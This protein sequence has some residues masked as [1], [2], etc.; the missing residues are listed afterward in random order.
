MRSLTLPPAGA[1]QL[2]DFDH[3]GYITRDEMLHMVDAI[4]KMVGNMVQ[5]PADEDTPEKRVN[6]IFA[7]MDTDRDGRLTWEEF[8]EG[9]KKDPS[10]VQVLSLYDGLVPTKPTS[11]SGRLSVGPTSAAVPADAGVVA[12]PA[13]AGADAG[14]AV[15]EA[16][17]DA[18]AAEASPAPAPDAVP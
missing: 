6:K 7:L 12:P 14:T 11:H 15:A 13:A 16:A 17:E 4:Y 3:N 18:G 9:S 2:Y 8:C 1:F 5:L 10:I